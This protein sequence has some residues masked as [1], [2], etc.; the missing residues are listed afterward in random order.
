[1][2]TPWFPNW[3]LKD[4]TG[5]FGPMKERPLKVDMPIT[6]IEIDGVTYFFGHTGKEFLPENIEELKAWARTQIAKW[7]PKSEVQRFS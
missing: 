4:G 6:E 7:W 5:I 1:M 2:S 3:K